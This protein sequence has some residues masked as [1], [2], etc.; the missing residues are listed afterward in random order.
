MWNPGE[1]RATRPLTPALSAPADDASFLRGVL[2]AIPAF[3]LR[4]DHEQRIRYVNG[5]HDGLILDEFIGRPVRGFVASEDLQR[6]EGRL[7]SDGRRDS[8]AFSRN[9][10]I[11]SNGFP[12]FTR[13]FTLTKERAYASNRAT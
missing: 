10:L 13:V 11:E 5:V 7:D 2:E 9:E 4:V 6:F 12:V 8:H 3:V 1:A